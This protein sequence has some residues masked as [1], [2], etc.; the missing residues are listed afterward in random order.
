MK[1]IHLFTHV[2]ESEIKKKTI[3]HQFFILFF[4]SQAEKT[5]EEV[6]GPEWRNITMI[7]LAPELEHS[8]EVIRYLRDNGVTVSLG[9]YHLNLN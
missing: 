6:Y 7:T 4:Q 5:I 9:V 3:S 8:S 1:H 2:R